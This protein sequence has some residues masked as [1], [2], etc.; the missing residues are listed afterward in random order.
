VT[1]RDGSIDILMVTYN[2]PEYTRLAVARLL[3]SCDESMRVW[4]WHNGEH[5]DTLDVVHSFADHPAVHRFHHSLKNR[6]LREPT[7]WV[8]QN[9]SG[10]FLSKV[11]D[12]CLVPDGWAQTLRQALTD[13]PELAVVGCWRFREEDFVPE[14]AERKLKTLAGG[15][16]IL[17]NCW[18]Q[19]SGFLL[20]REAVDRHGLL[21][22]KQSFPEYCKRLAYSGW[23]VGWYFPFLY[24]EHMD[25]PRSPYTLISSDEALDRMRP[26]TADRVGI[27][28]RDARIRQIRLFAMQCQAASTD[29]RQ[30]VGWRAIMDRLLWRAKGRPDRWAQYERLL[31]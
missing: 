13:V 29:P 28:T 5:A 31:P 3:E 7:N 1:V 15:H 21:R 23:L 12:D 26:L 24:E 11:D 27:R 18:V 14:I 20:R 4:L 17:Q 10:S 9:A 6:G 2:R 16:R 25:D 19:G 30:F 8:W 22:P